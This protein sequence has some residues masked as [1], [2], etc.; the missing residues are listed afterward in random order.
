MVKYHPKKNRFIH[1]YFK[2]IFITIV[3]VSL[4]NPNHS[5]SQSQPTYPRTVGYLSFILPI[6][7]MDKHTT[8][9]NFTNA[10][11]IGFPT[12]VNVLYSEKFGFSYEITPTIKVTDTG[13]KMSNLLFD[14]GPMFRFKKGFTIIP[15]LAF[16][17]SG[18]YGFSPVFNQIM[19][20]TKAVNYFMAM[21][22]PARF[23]NNAASSLGLNIQFG[24]IFN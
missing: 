4:F 5:F 18:R 24:C 8:T 21:S 9:T 2:L 11:S 20:R 6:V 23:G 14:P 17:T 7:I 12:G 3:P 13:S 19:K 16:E 1:F 10:T 22:L 15:R